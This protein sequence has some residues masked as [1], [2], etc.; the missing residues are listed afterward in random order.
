MENKNALWLVAEGEH[1]YLKIEINKEWIILIKERLDY[2]FSHIIESA[3]IEAK[4]NGDAV[5]Y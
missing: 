2:P 1:V 3:G 5:K 4:I